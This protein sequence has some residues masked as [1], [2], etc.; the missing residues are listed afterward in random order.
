MNARPLR[1][2][3]PPR[4]LERPALGE[5]RLRVVSALVMVPIVIL[6]AWFGE[7]SFAVIVLV[8]AALVFDEWSRMLK[9]ERQRELRAAG[10]AALAVITAAA[11]SYPLGVTLAIWLTMTVLIALLGA[12]LG[13]GDRAAWAGLG[14]LYAGMALVSLVLL[15][16]GP[17]GFAIIVFIFV[18]AWVTDIAAFFVGRRL[19]GPKLWPAVSP[20]KT[21]SGAIGGLV[22][23][24]I[25]GALLTL[26]LDLALSAELILFTATIAV[27]AQVG[28]LLESAVK[29]RFGVKD[30][31][32]LIPGHGGVMDRVDGLVVASAVAILF[33]AALGTFDPEP[34]TTLV[35]ILS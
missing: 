11:L 6:F 33:A 34:A 9:L 3:P 12:A 19:R 23:G 8:T 15:R 21:W 4:P 10:V 16:A 25:G 30:A 7:I 1:W 24:L 28:D 31:G 27:A 13:G 20:G 2:R 22:F 18:V 32:R 5:L 29:R 17:H 35:R 26:P 14:M